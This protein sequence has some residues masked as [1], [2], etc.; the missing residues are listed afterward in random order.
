MQTK[1]EF[2]IEL[3]RPLVSM[4]RQEIELVEDFYE[5]IP[6]KQK[7]GVEIMS[8][9]VYLKKSLLNVTTN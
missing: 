6:D 2:M 8:K 5:R 1:E 7:F 4:T 3:A 9:S